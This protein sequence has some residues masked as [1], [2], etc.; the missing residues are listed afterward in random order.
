[1]ETKKKRSSGGGGCFWLLVLGLCTLIC[2]GVL[3]VGASIQQ[4]EP[5]KAPEGG[6]NVHIL[7]NDGTRSPSCTSCD[8]GCCS[9]H[10]GC[11]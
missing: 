8:K 4:A 6:G 2:A 5:R 1:M 3:Y 7:C 10:G 9:G 11:K